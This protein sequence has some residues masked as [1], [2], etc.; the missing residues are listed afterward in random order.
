[1]S[2]SDTA[3]NTLVPRTYSILFDRM[4]LLASLVQ[5]FTMGDVAGSEGDVAR[6]ATHKVHHTI[7]ATRHTEARKFLANLS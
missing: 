2:P 4:A 1:L 5:Y 6:A 3:K 7:A